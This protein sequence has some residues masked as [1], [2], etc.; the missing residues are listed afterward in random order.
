MMEGFAMDALRAPEPLRLASWTTDIVRGST[1][2]AELPCVG[3][4]PLIADPEP[5][6][7]LGGCA[8]SAVTLVAT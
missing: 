2:R 8:V 5:Q 4:S 1:D 7:Q 6:Q 3:A